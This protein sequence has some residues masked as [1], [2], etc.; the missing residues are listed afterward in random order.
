MPHGVTTE[1]ASADYLPFVSL[2]VP[3][4]NEPPDMVIATLTSLTRLDYP[5]YEIIALDDNTADENLWRPVEE[6]CAAHGIRFM[7]F[8]DREGYKAGAL[9]EALQQADSRASLVGVVDSVVLS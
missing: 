7:H 9:N 3:A 2:H 4:Y 6:F 1:Q 5:N 8:E